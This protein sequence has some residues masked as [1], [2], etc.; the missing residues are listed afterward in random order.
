MKIQQWEMFKS[1]LWKKGWLKA[2]LSVYIVYHLCAVFFMPL[3]GS[4][5][6]R[7]LGPFLYPYAST[8]GLNT[9]WQFF[10][11]NPASSN[12][13]EYE[14]YYP[15]EPG[16]DEVRFETYQWP[17]KSR[18]GIIGENYNRRVYHSM[19]S[20]IDADR[21]TKFLV[22]WLCRKHKGAQS[23]ALRKVLTVLPEMESAQLRHGD[24][25][26]DFSKQVEV[27]SEEYFCPSA[28]EFQ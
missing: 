23:I 10:S 7:T 22:P 16:R 2:L 20:T 13:L 9:T 8:L 12:Y 11:P 3:S 21:T 24:R 14:V 25:V 15:Q 17:P 6:E 18:K 1:K 27:P 19:I 26:S 5:L 4:I 28:K